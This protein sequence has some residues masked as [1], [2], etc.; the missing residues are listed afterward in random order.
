MQVTPEN[1]T[2]NFDPGLPFTDCQNP[3]SKPDVDASRIKRNIESEI[4][5]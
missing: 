5:A 1:K 2:S 4:F 3:E